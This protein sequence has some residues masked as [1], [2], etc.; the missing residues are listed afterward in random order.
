MGF[1]NYMKAEINVFRERD[2]AIQS[3]M[4]VSLYP[5]FNAMLDCRLAH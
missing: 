1:F 3:S 5:S 2:P 4:E